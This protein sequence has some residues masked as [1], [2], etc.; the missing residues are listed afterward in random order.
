MTETLTPD[1][2]SRGWYPLSCGCHGFVFRHELL[3]RIPPQEFE[4]CE[5]AGMGGVK[6]E[7][8]RRLAP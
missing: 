8:L 4:F 7:T 1:A 6:I 5:K 2:I 3:S